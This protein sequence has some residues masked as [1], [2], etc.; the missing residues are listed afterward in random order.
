M[1]VKQHRLGGHLFKQRAVPHYSY[2]DSC[3]CIVIV[4]ITAPF[5]RIATY[6]V[7]HVLPE[8]WL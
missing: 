6:C 2:M 5:R 3:W 8:A 7:S 1:S 4:I